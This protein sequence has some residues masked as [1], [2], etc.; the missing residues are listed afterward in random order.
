MGISQFPLHS[1]Q[2]WSHFQGMNNIIHDL[3][4]LPDPNNSKL[5][6]IFW[7]YKLILIVK[8]N[9]SVQKS[10][11]ISRFEIGSMSKILKIFKVRILDF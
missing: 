3:S 9:L 7:F 11:E 1:N 5:S 8:K 4:C 2:N 10:W 6:R